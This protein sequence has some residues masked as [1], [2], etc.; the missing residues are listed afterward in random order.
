MCS[1]DTTTIEHSSSPQPAPQPECTRA[2]NH[3]IWPRVVERVKARRGTGLRADGHEHTGSSAFGAPPTPGRLTSDRLNFWIL[4]LEQ[5]VRTQ[6]FVLCCDQHRSQPPATWRP[7]RPCKCSFRVECASLGYDLTHLAPK[8]I[9]ASPLAACGPVCIAVHLG[10]TTAFF[11]LVEF[12]EVCRF[13]H[14][15][16]TKG[17]IVAVLASRFAH[18]GSRG[19]PQMCRGHTK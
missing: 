10:H 13:R 11:S 16:R 4:T 5:D 6:F 2:F 15:L 1:D 8:Q 7:L 12:V 9:L 14:G 3:N 19:Q 18:V 17:S